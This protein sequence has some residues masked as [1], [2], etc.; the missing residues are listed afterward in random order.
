M[1]IRLFLLSL[2]LLATTTPLAAME[3]IIKIDEECVN[4]IARSC[5]HPCTLVNVLERVRKTCDFRQSLECLQLGLKRAGKSIIDIKNNFGHTTLHIAIST[6]KTEVVKLLVALPE[7]QELAAMSTDKGH[8]ALFY[9]EYFRRTD[10]VAL[11]KAL[12]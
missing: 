11:L 1:N 8:T 5:Y 6:G 10:F 4:D 12:F 9:A 3:N 7:A 2:A